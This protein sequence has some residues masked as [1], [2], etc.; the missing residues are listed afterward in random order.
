MDAYIGEVR[1]MA[2]SFAPYGWIEC[3][4]QLVSITD[5]QALYAV[6]GT[7]Y[8]GDGRSTFAVPNLNGRSPMGV[9]NAIGSGVG[10]PIGTLQGTEGVTLTSPNQLPAHSHTLTMENI[11]LSSGTSNVTA[12][13]VPSGSW[14]SRPIHITSETTGPAIPFM[15]Q[16]VQPNTTLQP[17]TVGAAGQAQPH[18]NRQPFLTV[19]FCINWDGTF[20]TPS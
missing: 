9:G 17:N 15:T 16:G 12:A 8:G 4:G 5:Y 19:R 6:I 7:I 14:L 2:I 11:L 13:P 3:N 20:P 1:P 10:G 18:E